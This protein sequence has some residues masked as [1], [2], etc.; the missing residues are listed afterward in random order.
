MTA[1]RDRIV[2]EFDVR[3]FEGNPP[4]RAL[5]GTPL[6]LDFLELPSTNDILG[7]DLLDGIGRQAQVFGGSSGEFVQV[8]GRKEGFVAS[9]CQQTHFIAVIPDTVNRR[10]HLKEMSPRGLIFYSVSIGEC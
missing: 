5:L 8:V 4:E 1:V 6:E 3:R 2:L 10:G 9:I 7:T